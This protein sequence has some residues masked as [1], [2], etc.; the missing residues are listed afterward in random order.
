MSALPWLRTA[1]FRLPLGLSM[2]VEPGTFL[3]FERTQP[4]GVGAE[5]V[6]IAAPH[7]T[8]ALTLQASSGSSAVEGSFVPL[9]TGSLD[10]WTVQNSA[11]GN[12]T[13]HDGVL[14]VEGPAGWL[15]YDGQ[16]FTDFELRTEFRFITPDADSGIFVRAVGDGIFMRGWPGDSYQLQVRVPTTPSFLPPV[17]GIFRH[18]TPPGE[19][20]LDTEAVLKAFTGM[21]EWQQLEIELSGNT[22][23]ARLNGIEITRASGLVRRAG[24]IGIQGE[25]GT[26]E[27][28]SFDVRAR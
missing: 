26:I 5:S 23:A 7:S 2:L 18:G 27:Y 4:R 22:L 24:S 9:F 14:R 6:R 15:R 12:F 17:G 20:H 21:N 19:T 3:D 11:G 1:A 28:R 8:P 13:V 16:Q 10:G 25:T